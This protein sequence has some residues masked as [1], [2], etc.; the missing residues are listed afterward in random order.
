MNISK[1]RFI[2][3]M[4]CPKR[5]WLGSYR[6]ELADETDQ[7]AFQMGTMV[8]ELARD[9]FPGG[10]LVEYNDADGRN[11]ANMIDRTSALVAAG[12][13]IIYEAAFSHNGTFAICDILV[14]NGNACD[15]LEV[16]ASTGVKDV[17]IADVAFQR[18]VLESC[19]IPV[20][21]VYIVHINSGYERHGA[22]DLNELFTREDVTDR[23]DSI[24]PTIESSLQAAL[25]MSE[26]DGEPD[27]G[28]GMHCDDPYTCQFKGHCFSHIPANSVFDLADMHRDK[29]F[30]LYESG[31]ITFGDIRESGVRL[32]GKARIQVDTQ[33]D[34][35]EIVEREKIKGF[36]DSLW[37]PLY[38]LDFETINPAIPLFD[39][40]RPFQQIPTQYSLHCIDSENAQP[41][42]SGFLAEEG[43]DPRRLLAES[44]AAEIPQ[45]ACVLAYNMTFEKTIIRQLAAMYPDLSE[46][47]ESIA[48]NMHDL[49][50]PFQN[51][52][53]Y[54]KEMRGSHSIKAV[55]PA[56]FPDDPELSYDNLSGVSNGREASAAYLSLPHMAPEDRKRIRMELMEY[57]RLDTLAMV[58]IW[59]ELRRRML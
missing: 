31:V 26:A 19:K 37:Y 33:L 50:L 7:T 3:Y 55:L 23:A 30:K 8:G 48:R 45:D 13:Q 12:E 10:V 41:R 49:M 14:Q 11:I 16:K 54:K 29:K 47:L 4:Q 53:L 43:T 27:I 25:V 5:L 40:T 22:L 51:R 24:R 18:H 20:S 21:R 15:I 42:H 17:Y 58:R 59:E 9:L 39:G 46:S 57:C 38:F 36:L 52:Y 2:D 6:K 34:G 35:T 56:L 28:I 44:L 32:P 1:S